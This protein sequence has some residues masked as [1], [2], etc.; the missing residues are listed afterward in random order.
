MLILPNEILSILMNT[1]DDTSLR[2]L[3]L[4]CKR[5]FI[6][7]FD[8]LNIRRKMSLHTSECELNDMTPALYDIYTYVVDNLS[9]TYNAT[10]WMK[11]YDM[12]MTLYAMFDFENSK[13]IDAESKKVQITMKYDILQR[14]LNLHKHQD[15]KRLRNMLA[16]PIRQIENFLTSFRVL[17]KNKCV[18]CMFTIRI[19]VLR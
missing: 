3:S 18:I 2:S 10:S 8:V 7:S 16:Y 9:Q 17:K 4:C 6:L 11:V 13:H 12:T 1:V 19:L 5:I 15:R 14:C